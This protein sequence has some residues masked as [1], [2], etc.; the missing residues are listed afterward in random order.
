[1]LQHI[2]ATFWACRPRHRVKTFNEIVSEKNSGTVQYGMLPRDHTAARADKRVPSLP[3]PT[4][5]LRMK[6]TGDKVRRDIYQ[7]V[8]I[9]AGGLHGAPRAHRQA[10]HIDSSVPKS[11]YRSGGHG[12]ERAGT[13]CNRRG[14]RHLRG[15]PSVPRCGGATAP[16]AGPRKRRPEHHDETGSAASSLNFPKPRARDRT[17]ARSHAR[18]RAR[19]SARKCVA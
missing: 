14:G 1:M 16:D 15:A 18:A 19:A 5:A 12:A 3:K 10:E 13:D 11:P 17:L 6:S 4:S 7:V 2:V 9:H 8:R